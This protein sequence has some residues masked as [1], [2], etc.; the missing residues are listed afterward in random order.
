MNK[1]YVRNQEQKII[2][3]KELKGQLSDGIWENEKTDE[4]L[5]NVEVI[6]VNENE[7]FELGCNFSP[8]YYVDFCHNDLVLWLSDRI[9]EYVRDVDPNYCA[10]DLIIDLIDLTEIVFGWEED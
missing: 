9:V 8:K 3:D 5:W 10:D 7:D 6:V 4:R 2:F 1:L